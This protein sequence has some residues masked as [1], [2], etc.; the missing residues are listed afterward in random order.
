VIHAVKD[1]SHATTDVAFQK[2]TFATKA[3]IVA[4]TRTRLDVLAKRDSLNVTIR[5][6]A[7]TGHG[8]A[9]DTTTAEI[10]RT[11]Q[12]A[13]TRLALRDSSSAPLL[14]DA[15]LP[16]TRATAIVTVRMDLMRPLALAPTA[17]PAGRK[18]ILRVQIKPAVYQTN[19]SAM[20]TRNVAMVQTN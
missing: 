5:D 14:G 7:S 9:I 4:T 18:D 1:F 19:G 12:G 3:T 20:D 8:A 16:R 17:L 6:A 15:Y 2:V 13:A 10:I 11:K